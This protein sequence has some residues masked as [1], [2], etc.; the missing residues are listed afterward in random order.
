MIHI[1]ALRMCVLSSCFLENYFM[2]KNLTL[3]VWNCH[4]KMKIWSSGTFLSFI[5]IVIRCNPDGDTGYFYFKF[6]RFAQFLR[7]TTEILSQDVPWSLPF[8][9]FKLIIH[10]QSTFDA[11]YTEYLT[12]H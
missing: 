11:E 3:N 6:R 9:L 7:I 10:L 4:G 1:L 12:S 8:T 5:R 2:L